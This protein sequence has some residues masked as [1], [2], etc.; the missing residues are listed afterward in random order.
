MTS[1]MCVPTPASTPRS[2][3]FLHHSFTD[4]M[5]PCCQAVSTISPCRRSASAFRVSMPLERER[6]HGYNEHTLIHAGR[7]LDDKVHLPSFRPET[8]P[9]LRATVQG[10]VVE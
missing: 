10:D 7:G 8:R 1:G 3:T 4:S 5:S 6:V 9:A 2:R